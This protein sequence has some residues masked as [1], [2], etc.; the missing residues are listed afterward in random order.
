MQ[1]FGIYEP[2][3]SRQTVMLKCDK[4]GQMNKIQFT[5]A[6]SMGDQHYYVSGTVAKGY[7]KRSNGSVMCYDVKLTELEPI[8]YQQG[9]VHLI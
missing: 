9:C 6:P 4:I 7:P 2:N 1:Y 3:Y 5:K 8:E